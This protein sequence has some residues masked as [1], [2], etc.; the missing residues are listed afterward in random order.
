MTAAAKAE[1]RPI[2]AGDLAEAVRVRYAPPEWHC[3]SE[4]TLAGRRLDVVAL[5]LWAARR[6]TIVGFEIKASRGDW[7][8]ELAAFQKAEQW[9]QVCDAFYVVTPPKTIRSDELPDGWGH[10]ELCGSRMFTRR[11]AAVRNPVST[12]IPREIAA[13]FIGRLI[14]E[15]VRFE[16]RDQMT[17]RAELAEEIRK[18]V[19]QRVERERTSADAELRRKAELYDKILAALGLRPNWQDDRA[20]RAAKLLTAVSLDRTLPARIANL[21]DGVTRD[22][23]ALHEAVQILDEGPVSDADDLFEG[24]GDGLPVRA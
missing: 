16:H 13:R 20:L 24:D 2:C 4:V 11:I 14:D 17:I 12:T 22:L 21:V 5:N 18:T 3:E 9:I 10:L 7:M 15:R 6:H 19:E 8:R 1:A 23:K